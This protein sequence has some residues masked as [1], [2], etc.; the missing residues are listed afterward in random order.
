MYIDQKEWLDDPL[1]SPPSSSAAAPSAAPLPPFAASGVRSNSAA[2]CGF[3]RVHVA[4]ALP[5]P[6]PATELCD[7]RVVLPPMSAERG[8]WSAP[9]HLA[10]AGGALVSPRAQSQGKCA[11]QSGWITGR[12]TTIEPVPVGVGPLRLSQ[13][14]VVGATRL[15]AGVFG[16][17]G[18]APANALL[19]QADRLPTFAAGGSAFSLN[20]ASAKGRA[21]L[22]GQG[23]SCGCF[24]SSGGSVQLELGLER[25]IYWKSDTGSCKAAAGAG[26]AGGRDDDPPAGPGGG[27]E[28]TALD[29]QGGGGGAQRR[30]SGG[31][32]ASTPTPPRECISLDS[33]LRSPVPRRGVRAPRPALGPAAPRSAPCA[34]RPAL[35][36][37]RR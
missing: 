25:T 32:G 21:K 3:W 19:S 22:L 18:P 10:E 8:A 6:P 13:P 36:R 1:P 12:N 26:K 28:L 33:R 24:P 27:I 15:Q 7:V 9:D 31:G 5:P 2:G 14:V 35:R 11:S 29:E 30:A 17:P 37:G 16:G 23:K 4:K 34:A 20:S